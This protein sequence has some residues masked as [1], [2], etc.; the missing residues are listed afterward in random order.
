MAAA[1]FI[2]PA[3]GSKTAL[4]E[5]VRMPPDPLAAKTGMTKAQVRAIAGPPDIPSPY[6][7]GRDCWMYFPHKSGIN[8]HTLRI[9]FVSGRVAMIQTPMTGS[10]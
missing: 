1:I 3:C 7:S 4:T 9:C 10:G 6:P 2:L 8:V 5:T